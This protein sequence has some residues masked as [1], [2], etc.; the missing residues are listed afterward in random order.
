MSKNRGL[1]SGFPDHARRLSGMIDNDDNL[2]LSTVVYQPPQGREVAAIGSITD[3]PNPDSNVSQIYWRPDGKMFFWFE[4]GDNFRR[5]SCSTPWDMSTGVQDQTAFMASWFGI[6]ANYAFWFRRDGLKVYFCDQVHDGFIEF[7]LRTAWDIS[8]S[9]LIRHNEDFNGVA[10][11]MDA[12][13]YNDVIWGCKFGDSGNKFYVMVLTDDDIR[14]Y[15]LSTAYD[16]TSITYDGLVDLN[17]NGGNSGPIGFDWKPDGSTLWIVDIVGDVVAEYSVTTAWDITSGITEEQTFSVAGQETAPTD[18][19]WKPDG[20]MFFICGIAGRGIDTYSCSTN[21]DISTASHVRYRAI[22]TRPMQI[23]WNDDGTQ[24]IYNRDET[25]YDSYVYVIN[26]GTAYDTSSITTSADILLTTNHWDRN[27]NHNNYNGLI[28]TTY[29]DGI[30][31]CTYGGA[32]GEFLTVFGGRINANDAILQFPLKTEYDA[33]TYYNGVINL[34]SYSTTNTDV[35]AIHVSPDGTLF[36]AFDRATQRIV[37]VQT[38]V[39]WLLGTESLHHTNLGRSELIQRANTSVDD[40]GFYFFEDGVH[41]AMFDKTNDVITI[42]RSNRPPHRFDNAEFVVVSEVT[43]AWVFKNDDENNTEGYL[44][45]GLVSNQIR[46]FADDINAFQV[47]YPPTGP[48][49][50]LMDEGLNRCFRLPLRLHT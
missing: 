20:S 17:S 2:A 43:A 11:F 1:I 5:I 40:L 8:Q 4:A 28:N 22:N 29:I 47:I 33:T 24:L 25:S 34:R 13:G 26:F 35:K 39:P 27:I 42:H 23:T 10:Q 7:S 14:Q 46:Q 3:G 41:V 6:T 19:T 45:A 38:T 18:I 36:S 48:E 15:S 32:D 12:G 16:V 50:F 37:T 30:R 44:P 9:S 49:I 31:A 21:W